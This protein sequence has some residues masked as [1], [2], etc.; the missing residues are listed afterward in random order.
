MQWVSSQGWLPISLAA[1][2]ALFAGEQDVLLLAERIRLEQREL[3]RITAQRTDGRR[4]VELILEVDGRTYGPL[5]HKVRFET[6]ETSIELRLVPQRTELVSPVRLVP[7]VF[8]PDLPVKQTEQS[9]PV[10]KTTPLITNT[11]TARAAL[12]LSALDDAEV[13]VC[14]ALHR[15]R[16]CL[17]EPIEITRK[18]HI[19]SVHGLAHSNEHKA[20]LLA[21]L[22]EL[23]A[24]PFVK[25]KIQTIQE[26]LQSVQKS[27]SLTSGGREAPAEESAIHFFSGT[28]LIQDELERYYATYRTPG[29]TETVQQ[30]IALLSNEA[31]ILADA[32]RAEAW[33]LRRLAERF[34][35][36]RLAVL[37]PESRWL[38]EVITR[39]HLAGLRANTVR[40]KQLAEPVLLSI[41]AI[42]ETFAG[43]AEAIHQPTSAGDLP[44]STENLTQL[45]SDLFSKAEETGR[46]VHGLFAGANLGD[47]KGPEAAAKLLAL[48]QNLISTSR[49][50]DA[51]IEGRFLGN[52]ALTSETKEPKGSGPHGTR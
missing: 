31:T 25:V 42:P 15:L 20:K 44:A 21:A 26:R 30:K 14:Y 35:P 17:G 2:V 11:P 4:K 19:L 29:D 39:D 33:A 46:L 13:E 10:A 52:P 32:V 38:I 48:F 49:L 16:F 34:P 18:A 37:R 27:P 7:A 28:L 8:E 51:R 3:I 36:A 9:A 43:D 40:T 41:A 50:L 5:L 23:R 24:A 45:S 1:N 47:Q 6:A 12:T 22:A